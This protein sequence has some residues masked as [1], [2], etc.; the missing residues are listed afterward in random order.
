[1]WVGAKT[2][3]IKNLLPF[4]KMSSLLEVRKIQVFPCLLIP[5][6][7]AQNTRLS[8]HLPNLYSTV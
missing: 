2:S 6:N 1:M 8:S 3:R 7:T 4:I 5:S